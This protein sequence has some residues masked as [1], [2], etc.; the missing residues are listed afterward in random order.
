MADAANSKPMPE[1]MTRPLMSVTIRGGLTKPKPWESSRV[2]LEDRAPGCYEQSTEYACTRPIIGTGTWIKRATSG[3]V[4]ICTN[5]R[6][7]ET[8]HGARSGQGR[9]SGS[10]SIT[11]MRLRMSLVLRW[12]VFAA[13]LRS[14]A[15]FASRVSLSRARSWG[16]W[17]DASEERDRQA[18]GR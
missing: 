3:D 1:E 12:A 15:S 9:P 17:R 8:D 14:V 6:T 13:N 2:W 4:K 7:R 16:R 5:R 10:T 11:L 18:I